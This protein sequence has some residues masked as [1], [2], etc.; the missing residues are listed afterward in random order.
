MRLPPV[1]VI[2]HTLPTAPTSIVSF[3]PFSRFSCPAIAFA[4]FLQLPFSNPGNLSHTSSNVSESNFS[5]LPVLFPEPS[6]I[7]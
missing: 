3:T 5:F 2:R 4:Y 6:D 7:N 1:A